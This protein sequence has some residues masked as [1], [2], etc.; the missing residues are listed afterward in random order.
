MIHTLA[1]KKSKHKLFSL[2]SAIILISTLLAPLP[3]TVYAVAAPNPLSPADGTITTIVNYPPLGV[4]TVVWQA[5]AD[6]TLYK[7]QFSSDI[8]FSTIGLEINTPLISYT[9]TAMSGSLFADGDWYWRVR[10]EKPNVS[11]FSTPL[12][13]YKLWASDDNRPTLVSPYYDQILDFYTSPTFTWQRVIGASQYRFQIASSP[14]GFA[15]PVYNQTTL[16]NSHQPTTKLANGQYYWRVIPLD[17]ASHQGKESEVGAFQLLYGTSTLGEVPELYTPANYSQ[18]QFTP[19]YHWEAIPGAEKYQLEYMT[20]DGVCEYGSGT[21]IETRNTTYT[22][23]TTYSNDNY[24]WHVRVVSGASNGEWSETWHF[25]K[26]WDIQPVLLTPTNNYEFGIYPL[27]TWAPVPGAAYYKIEIAIDQVW[28]TP[29]DVRD[30]GNPWYTP[31]KYYGTIPYPY[32]WRVTP[33]DWNNHAGATSVVDSFQSYYTSTAPALVY[34][35]YY[36][37]PNDPNVYGDV[38]LNPYEDN[39]APYP[40]FIWQRPNNP[41]PWGGT[42]A[43]AYRLQVS[44]NS[45]FTD[46]VWTVDT[47]S[48]HAA[49]TTDHTFDDGGPIVGQNYYW[50]VCPLDMLGGSCKTVPVRGDEWWSQIWRARFDPAFAQPAT[51][52]DAPVPLRPENADEWVEA[53]PL[54]EWRAFEGADFYEVEVNIESTFPVTGTV[55]SEQVPFPAFSSETSIAQRFLGILDYGTYYWR[56]H[57]NSSGTWSDWS[58]PRRFQIASQSEWRYARTIGDVKNRLKIGEDESEGIGTYDLTTLYASNSNEN[59]YFGFDVSLD[60]ATT[61]TYALFIDIDHVDGSGAGINPAG[62]QYNV[63]T[64]SAHEPEFAVYVDQINGVVNK[65]NTWIFTFENEIWNDGQKLSDLAAGN[66]Y[67]N[68][69]YLELQIPASAIGMSDFT[70]SIS[71]MLFSTMNDDVADA[72]PADKVADN[73]GL[74]SRFTS[75][76]EHMNLLYPFN[77]DG[78]NDPTAYPTVG[79]F[80]W[81]FPTGTDPSGVDLNPPSPWAGS[82]LHACLDAACTTIVDT[83][84]QEAT[85]H[86]FA[87]AN[88]TLLDDVSGDTTYYWRVQPRYLHSNVEYYGAYNSGYSFMRE[89]FVPQNLQTSV[90]FATPTFTWDLVEG[91]GSYDFQVSKGPDFGNSDLIIN[92]TGLTQNTYTPVIA[93]EEREYWW[94]VRAR[95]YGNFTS[96]WSTVNTFV[97]DL[98]TITGLTPNDPYGQTVFEYAPT[99]C[100]DHLIAYDA[101][102]PVLTAWRYK[103]EVSKDPNFSA[104]FDSATTEQNCWTPTKGYDDGTYYWH[105]AMID[106]NGHLAPYGDAVQ[107]TKQYPIATLISPVGSVETTPTFVWTAVDGAKNYSLQISKNPG[108]TPLFDSIETINTQYTPTKLYDINQIYYWRVAMRDHEGKY[109]P[110]NDAMIIVGEVYLSELP[111]VSK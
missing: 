108:F 51:N 45:I 33:Y 111:I 93:L 28:S 79:P 101:G 10:V 77:T 24:C 2:F 49:P 55:L 65:E 100:W 78:G 60:P 16:S 90:T 18:M 5:V 54:F 37:P 95:R 1:G 96:D 75:V 107:F 19:T 73:T 29:F 99:M 11:P 98:P 62:R 91:A 34:P 31:R 9:P 4:P 68:S 89:G 63:S 50:R 48:T 17:G 57:A 40:V 14:E 42:Y 7:L 94:R 23:I 15:T 110:Y 102:I 61:N 25:R 59:W 32:A 105:V 56:V 86:Y 76:T 21:I 81:D 87:S 46:I 36:Y 64:I 8:G 22:P 43:P 53:T 70:G 104:I 12:R 92:I 85:P 20:D 82:M 41:Y 26:Q 44:T 72:V 6:A 67:F 80:L 74:L 71:T 39:T 97:L 30:T 109:G 88:Q 84:E 38:V 52:G 103:V 13:F 58:E 69:N 35:L 47:E 106:G 3:S 27:Y 83:I 66:L